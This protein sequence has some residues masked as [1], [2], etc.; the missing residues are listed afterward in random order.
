MTDRLGLATRTMKA[1]RRSTCSA[2]R[3]VILPGMQ[4]ARVTDPPA[5]VHVGCV[6]VVAALQLVSRE[7]GGEVIGVIDGEAD[8]KPDRFR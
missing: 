7:L 5:W 4:I 2:C 8:V 3:R 6:E 1:R